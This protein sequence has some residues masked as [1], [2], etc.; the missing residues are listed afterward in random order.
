MKIFLGRITIHDLNYDLRCFCSDI[1]VK[2]VIHIFLP[3]DPFLDVCLLGAVLYPQPHGGSCSVQV[4]NW[5]MCCPA[6]LSKA[7][8]QKK[9]CS[10]QLQLVG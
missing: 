9:D 2:V 8:E 10:R 3:F 1:V 4:E 6:K 5:C 7:A